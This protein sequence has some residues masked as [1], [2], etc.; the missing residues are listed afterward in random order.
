MKPPAPRAPSAAPS[1][2]AVQERLH[3]LITAPAGVRA[4]LDA[5]GLDEAALAEIVRGDARRSPVERLDIYANMY[6]FRILD[7]LRDDFP[8]LAALTGPDRFHNLITDYLA[9]C[10]P[11]HPSIRDVGARLPSFL[12]EHALA[13]ERPWLAELARLEWTRL[14]VFDAADAPLVTVDA[15]RAL[16]PDAFAALPLPLI[17]AHARLRTLYAVD[18]TWRAVEGGHPPIDP[19]RAPRTLLVWRH[20]CAVFHRPVEKLESDALDLAAA[21]RPFGAVCD[22]VSARVPADDAPR[23]A[24]ELLLRWTSDGLIAAV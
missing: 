20:D 8:S 19:T 5:L 24:F 4:G 12:A 22:L 3:A 23:V 10:P 6:F 18:E 2:R 9:A 1:L 14:D 17:P 13:G 11:V 16:D 15:L 21:G 7:V